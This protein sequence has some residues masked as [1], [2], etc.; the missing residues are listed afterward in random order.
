MPR[1]PLESHFSAEYL[2]AL[3]A[4][5]DGNLPLA[6]PAAAT[7]ASG[8]DTDSQHAAA[9]GSGGGG[10]HL[11]SLAAGAHEAYAMAAG[12]EERAELARLA[13][14]WLDGTI[15]DPALLPPLAS[16]SPAALRSLLLLCM[17]L[18]WEAVTGCYFS[19]DLLALRR[20]Q[21]R[22]AKA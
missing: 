7:A 17:Q 14:A 5:V 1:W 11:A 2:D 10:V 20:A 3:L 21:R 16:C 8:P 13:G 22:W 6:Q 4:E 19:L 15:S 9:G 18:E 12:S